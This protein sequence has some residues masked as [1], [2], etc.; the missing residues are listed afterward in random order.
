MKRLSCALALGLFALGL[1]GEALGQ[2][3]PS[4]NVRIVV[5]FP[6]GGGVD[7]M[8]RIIGTKL[9]DRLGQTVLV[10]HKPGAGGN[11]GADVVAKSPP[12]GYTVLLT[13]NGLSASPALYRSLPFDPVK[14]FEPITQV[15]ASQFVLV[16]SPKLEAKTL[17]DVIA[18]ARAKPGKLNYGSSGVGAPLHMQAEMFKH[19]AGLD[20]AHIPYRGD[21]PMLTALLAG[22]I[23]IGFMPVG[24]G[25]AQVQSGAVKGLAVTGRKRLKALPD[26]P[27]LAESG[28][29]GLEDGSW[30]GL[31]APAGTPRDIVVRL[32][33]EMAEVL[34]SPDVVQRI[35]VTGNEPVGSTPDEFAAFFKADVAKFA[36]VVADAK[37]P[38]FD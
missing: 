29:K 35:S 8:A 22:D 27:T 3:Y 17:Q 21:A 13:V 23:D 14:A 19:G 24:T 36:K 34:K 2:S 5:P 16:G 10:E 38:K 9:S 26:L 37:I 28:V 20:I 15:A 32:Q 18:L 1:A 33:K 25:V 31:F 12:D 7:T 6:A 30:Y 4:K 11:I